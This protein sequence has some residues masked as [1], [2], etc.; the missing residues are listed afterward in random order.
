MIA[1]GRDWPFAPLG[2][3]LRFKILFSVKVGGIFKLMTARRVCTAS[4]VCNNTSTP[5]GHNRRQVS[6]VEDSRGSSRRGPR[7]Q[8]GRCLRTPANLLVCSSSQSSRLLESERDRQVCEMQ[9]LEMQPRIVRAA[10]ALRPPR[11]SRRSAKNAEKRHR[12]LPPNA[13]A[14]ALATKVSCVS[15]S[16]KKKKERESPPGEPKGASPACLSTSPVWSGAHGVYD[17][18]EYRALDGLGNAAAVDSSR[19]S[20]CLANFLE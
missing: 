20:A 10:K 6:W 3:F 12:S 2:I 9:T 17:L 8:S 14:A 7:R 13:R 19:F 11:P 18:H 5:W 1:Q 15:E 16:G 4:G